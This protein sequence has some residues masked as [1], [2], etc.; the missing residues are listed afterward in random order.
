[1]TVTY[2]VI[3][4]RD[5]R[6]QRAVGQVKSSKA[7]SSL[8]KKTKNENK[9]TFI[10]GD[11]EKRVNWKQW[12]FRAPSHHW[13]NGALS[14]C[15]SCWFCLWSCLGWN[16][17]SEFLECVRSPHKHTK[18]PKKHQR[19]CGTEQ[20]RRKWLRLEY[21]TNLLLNRKQAS[22]LEQSTQHVMSVWFGVH[23]TKSFLEFVLEGP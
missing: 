9:K 22:V 23:V 1:M 12:V 6:V 13:R 10:S 21:K 5:E 14:T 18:I 7:T 3:I 2:S 11:V 17:Y 8:Q 4:V 19:I 15:Y 16:I 20:S